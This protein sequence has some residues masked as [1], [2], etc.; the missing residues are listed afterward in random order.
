MINKIAYA[1]FKD[2]AS[3]LNPS[4]AHLYTPNDIR[5]A[6]TSVRAKRKAKQHTSASLKDLEGKLV[7][8]LRIKLDMFDIL[9]VVKRNQT[10]GVISQSRIDQLP[11]KFCHRRNVR[12]SKFYQTKVSIQNG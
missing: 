5:A 9:R 12:S 3:G 2:L 1:R 6:I 10:T 7:R 4:L 11:S 8:E